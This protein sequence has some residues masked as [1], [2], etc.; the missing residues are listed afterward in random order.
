MYFEHVQS[1]VC[2]ITL[3][4]CAPK[5]HEFHNFLSYWHQGKST[6]SSYTHVIKV[7]YFSFEARNKIYDKNSPCTLTDL[8]WHMGNQIKLRPEYLH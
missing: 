3:L 1:S 4:M 5:L 2:F 6:G 8:I 7:S